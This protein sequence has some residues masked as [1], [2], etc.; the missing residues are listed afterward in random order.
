MV[1]RY[2]LLE[3]TLTF[4]RPVRYIIVIK[5]E[6]RNLHTAYLPYRNTGV[7]FPIESVLVWYFLLAVQRKLKVIGNILEMGVEHGGTAFLEVVSLK[8]AEALTLIDLKQSARYVQMAETLPDTVR[9]KSLF[10]NA[11]HGLRH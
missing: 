9:K 1:K 5:D 6:I 3:N 11:P 4:H 10:M 8:D 7:P 2:T